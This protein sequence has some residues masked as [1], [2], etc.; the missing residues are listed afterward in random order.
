MLRIVLARPLVKWAS[1]SLSVYLAL[2]FW[3]NAAT[4]ILLQEPRQPPS[5]L[6]M[7]FTLLL[8]TRAFFFAQSWSWILSGVLTLGLVINGYPDLCVILLVPLA[9]VA[10]RMRYPAASTTLLARHVPIPWPVVLTP[11]ERFLHMHVIGPTGSGKSS[12][13]LMPLISQDII[14]DYGLLV[15]EPKGDLSQTAY[16]D[17]LKAGRCV[18]R[19]MPRDEACPH[20][21]PLSGKTEAA[22]EGLALCLDQ[23]SQGGHPYY[24]VAA[25]VQLLHAVRVIKTTIGE[26]ADIGHVLN[27]FRDI[28]W[29]KQLVKA[30]GDVS[31]QAYFQEQ[32]GRKAN[33][34][35]EDHQG[36]LNRLE[37]LW[38][39]PVVRRVL[40][41]PADFTWEEVLRD[42][43]IVLCPLSLADLGE[44]ARALGVLIWHGL[45]QAAYQRDPSG[46]HTPF[47]AYLDEFYQW[48]SEDL[49]DFL[50]LARGYS[51][52][53]ILAHQDMGQLSEQLQQAVMANARQRIVL[54]G[55]AADDVAQF[56]HSAAPYAVDLRLRYLRRG[57]AVVQM[58][59][60]GQLQPPRLVKLAHRPLVG[61]TLP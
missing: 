50:A 54:P 28:T 30:S 23:L 59:Q 12:S 51:I 8:A 27:F 13:V 19:F 41:A 11:D 7:G 24:A 36:L 9:V 52:G 20:F 53:L 32:W 5:T 15:L 40:S 49:G 42:H 21:N 14:H 56:R 22:A 57:R 55:S 17:A 29:Q 16:E 4:H 48:V 2:F 61:I 35:R 47:F 18:I 33:V 25:R 31:A 26:E 45:A 6:L 46:Q 10:M 3:V 60:R 43:W 37:L 58:T 38:A 1:A 39:N 34:A 44:S